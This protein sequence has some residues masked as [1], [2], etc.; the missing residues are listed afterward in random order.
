L[1]HECVVLTAHLDHLGV[2]TPVDGDSIWNGAMDNASGVATLLEIARAASRP[3]NRPRRT[4]V[5]V[6]TTAEEMGL[7][8]SRYFAGRPPVPLERVVAVLNMDMTLPIVPLQRLI[9]FGLDESSLGDQ[10]REVLAGLGI[11]AQEDPQPARNR[12]VRSDQYSF[13]ARGVP[14][15]A[16]TF[17]YHAGSSEESLLT[18]WVRSRYHAPSDDL[19]QPVDREAADRLTAAL[20]T[21]T[22]SVADARQP[23]RWKATSFFTRF[24]E[25]RKGS[26]P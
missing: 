26:R 4:L 19:A 14:S 16:F 24:S 15:L 22:R 9:V 11:E 5:F 1:R 23:P 6:A 25:K 13:I 20:L 18:G 12:F 3:E 2:G 10:A 7:L 8:G 21:L 17:G